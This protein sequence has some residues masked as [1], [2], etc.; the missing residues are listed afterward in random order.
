ML[1]YFGEGLPAMSNKALT[2]LL[3]ASKKRKHLE[4]EE[5]A[6]LMKKQDWKCGICGDTHSVR[7]AEFDNVTPLCASYGEQAFQA[8][9]PHCHSSRTAN[10]ERPDDDPL[11]R[12]VSV[13]VWKQFAEP[14][15]SWPSRSVLLRPRTRKAR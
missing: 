5:K 4:D 6:E 14:I 1:D 9:R 12:H 15:S 10:E 13:A 3:K 2:A 8:V 11:T 7:T